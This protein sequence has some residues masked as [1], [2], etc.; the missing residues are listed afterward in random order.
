MSI[1][2]NACG[3]RGNTRGH[4][5]RRFPLQLVSADQPR[6][7]VPQR[8]A[9]VAIVIVGGVIRYAAHTLAAV[10]CRDPHNRIGHVLFLQVVR[11]G[12]SLHP[13]RYD[14]YFNAFDLH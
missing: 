12:K 10:L 14:N 13:W 9:S 8:L 4:K 6:D 7:Q 3:G 11:L 1:A 2:A 5:P